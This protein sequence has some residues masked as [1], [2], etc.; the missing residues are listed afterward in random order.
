M[1]N[2]TK[3]ERARRQVQHDFDVALCN[4]YT[5][6]KLYYEDEEAFMYVI[7]AEMDPIRIA[8]N[9]CGFI[10]IGGEEYS[11]AMLSGSAL[12]EIANMEDSA[13]ALYED[14]EVKE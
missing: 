7:D 2:I 14:M 1:G 13:R 8:Y 9:Y 6:W 5:P 11:Y 10:Q 3:A 4:G 12:R